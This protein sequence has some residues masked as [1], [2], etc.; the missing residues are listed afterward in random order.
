MFVSV[1]TNV[2]RET[3][4]RSAI[5]ALQHRF[6]EL[7]ISP[8]YESPAEGFDGAPFYNLVV[9]LHSSEPVERIAAALK[10]IE[11][12]HARQPADGKFA[13]RTLDLDL[14]TYGDVCMQLD[15]FELPRADILRYAFVLRPLADLAPEAAHP[16]SGL[17]YRAHWQ[18]FE[19]PADLQPV[20]LTFR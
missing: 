10:Q 1:G 7:R 13:S 3:N 11:R 8:A 12:D 19:G 9:M 2:E 20:A 4:L 6:G 15:G 18:A 16:R 5:A 14:L 17:S